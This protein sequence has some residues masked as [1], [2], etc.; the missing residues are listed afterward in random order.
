MRRSGVCPLDTLEPLKQLL[1][2]H[3]EHVKG[4]ILIGDIYTN[5]KKDLDKAEA[6]YIR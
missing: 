3:P 1:E 5:N 6:C 2:H 4:L